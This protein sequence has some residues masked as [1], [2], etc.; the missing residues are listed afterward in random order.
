MSYRHPRW[1]D[2]GKTADDLDREANWICFF[3][4]LA[5]PFTFG[6]TL[7]PAIFALAG[8]VSANPISAER[9]KKNREW[10]KQ[11]LQEMS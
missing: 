4:V 7:I 11:L 5:A 9:R 8:T 3:L 1:Y 10:L 6:I 2:Y